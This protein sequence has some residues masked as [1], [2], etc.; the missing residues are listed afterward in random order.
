MEDTLLKCKFL[1]TG[2]RQCECCWWSGLFTAT[3][4]AHWYHKETGIIRCELS[5]ADNL[6]VGHYFILVSS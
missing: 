4:L 2:D 3:A 1:L 5:T 6:I